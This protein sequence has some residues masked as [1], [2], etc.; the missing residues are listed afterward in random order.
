MKDKATGAP[1]AVVLGGTGHIG[2]AISR[3]FC[4]AGYEVLAVGHRDVARP[5]LD[6][7]PIEIA[8]GDD[9]DPRQLREWCRDASVVIDSGTVYPV[10]MFGRP[11]RETRAAALSRL[12]SVLDAAKEAQAAFVLISS[13]TTLPRREGV[14]ASLQRGAL[15][16]SHPYFDLKEN[17]ERAV[18]AHLS[19]GHR[20][21]IIAPGTCFGPFDLKPRTQTFVP[22]LLSGKVPVVAKQEMNVI[23]VR[24]VADVVFAARNGQ[25][26]RPITVFGHN[27][28]LMELSKTICQLG[29]AAAPKMAVPTALGTAGFYWM[30]TAYAVAG[31]KTPWP[32]L[33]MLLLAASYPEQPSAQ[34][35]LLHP[36]LRPLDETLRDAID[37][38]RKIGYL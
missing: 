6:D 28:S 11:A 26:S 8:L 17:V 7:L 27:L 22:M 1:K 33:A 5:N 4:A 12:H 30:E 21:A 20:G 36:S 29:D 18:Q 34:Q 2:A 10:W 35:R 14:L 31:K 23:D 37:W 15:Y 19:A 16:G 13:F 32:S 25:D 9:T 24:D 38:Y 3:R